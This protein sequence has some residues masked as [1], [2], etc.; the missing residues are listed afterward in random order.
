MENEVPKEE[1]KRKRMKNKIKINRI[2]DI[3]PMTIVHMR[4]GK[5]AIVEACCDDT[6]VNSLE[7]DE[8][9][10]YD[11]HHFMKDEWEHV[12]YGIGEDIYSTFIDFQKRYNE[13]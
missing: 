1:N 3:Y 4:H 10:Q 7:G 8:E 2:E 6:C 12:N 5:F 11:P 9:W 13:R